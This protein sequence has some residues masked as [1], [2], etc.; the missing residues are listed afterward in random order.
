MVD[1]IGRR[2]FLRLSAMAAAGAAAVACQPQTVVVKE[3]VEVEK[4]VKETVEVEKVVKETVQVQVEK[5]VTKVVEKEKIVEVT[6]V[7]ER[8]SPMFQEMVQAGTLP[9]LE[10]RLP[11][12]PATCV[13]VPAD[14]IDLEIGRHG[15]TLRMVHSAPGSDP[16]VFC[17]NNDALVRGPGLFAE[18]VVGNIVKTFQVTDRETVF[19][20]YMREG[21]KWS[22]GTPLTT[23]DVR[24]AYEDVLMNEEITPTFPQWMRSG[25]R[26][27]GEP[28]Q[29]QVLDDYTFRITFAEPYGGFIAQLAIVAWRG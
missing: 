3:T 13:D 16:Y 5:E 15:G 17:M 6:G 24:F 21:M 11:V 22:D 26:V 4:V 20:F 14:E 10:E 9:P 7:S 8:Q 27:G 23:E 12:V 29:L 2:Q 18:G 25:N 19:T 28:M 1:Q